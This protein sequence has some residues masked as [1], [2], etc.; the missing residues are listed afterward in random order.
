MSDTD[1]VYDQTTPDVAA[2]AAPQDDDWEAY[3]PPQQQAAPLPSME[4]YQARPPADD[5]EPYQ[6]KPEAHGALGTFT[7]ELAHDIGPAAAGA[8]AGA[9]TYGAAASVFP[10]IGTVG[11]LVAGGVGGFLGGMAAEKVQQTG[12]DLI[13]N[14][15]ADALQRAADAEAHPWAAAAASG[16]SNL[17]GFGRGAAGQA[18]AR[19]LGAGVGGGVATAQEAYQQGG[20][21]F[22]PAGIAKAAP[23]VLAQT[24]AGALFPRPRG[25]VQAAEAWG[26]RMAGARPAAAPP[27]A[28]PPP[29]GPAQGDFG[30]PEATVPNAQAGLPFYEAP[31]PY[32]PRAPGQGPVIGHP[33]LNLGTPAGEQGQLDLPV[34]EGRGGQGGL[35]VRANPEQD[36]MLNALGDVDTTPFQRRGMNTD[37]DLRNLVNSDNPNAVWHSVN[38]WEDRRPAILNYGEGQQDATLNRMQTLENSFLE[39]NENIRDR[40][41]YSQL[42]RQAGI[43]PATGQ[44]NW[45]RL[46]QPDGPLGA[47]DVR[48]LMELS[49]K[50]QALLAGDAAS[51]STFGAAQGRQAPHGSPGALAA[52]GTAE[53]QAPPPKPM[54]DEPGHG[55]EDYGK[56]QPTGE[57]GGGVNVQQPG[58]PDPTLGSVLKPPEQGNLFDQPPPM[59]EH[60]PEP[61][62]PA[63]P[64][65]PGPPAAAP[66]PAPAEHPPAPAGPPQA[67][68]AE[69]KQTVG[70]LSLVQT[71]DGK[72]TVQDA[73]GNILSAHD[74]KGQAY[75]SRNKFLNA[76]AQAPETET[77]P[78]AAPVK[79]EPEAPPAAAEV[80]KAPE[81]PKPAPKGPNILHKMEPE[82]VFIRDIEGDIKKGHYDA[83]IAPTKSLADFKRAAEARGWVEGAFGKGRAFFSPDG[84]HYMLA[85]APVEGNN[86]NVQWGRVPKDI[87]PPGKAPAAAPKAAPAAEPQAP[88]VTPTQIEGRQPGD[89]RT[90]R[91]DISAADYAQR[92]AELRADKPRP[93]NKLWNDPSK[94]DPVAVARQQQAIKDW[95]SE[96]NRVSKMQKLALARDNAAMQAK[97]AEAPTAPKEPK[98]FDGTSDAAKKFA[99]GKPE[100]VSFLAKIG[101]P[102]QTLKVMDKTTLAD[103]LD[104]YQP[105]PGLWGD[106]QNLVAQRLKARVGNMPVYLIP[107]KEMAKYN[108]LNDVGFYHRGEDFVVI[109]EAFLN[110]P[111]RMAHVVFHEA[112]HAITAHALAHDNKLID[113]THAIMRDV[114]QK[115][116]P[117]LLAQQEHGYGIYGGTYDKKTKVLNAREFIAEVHSNPEFQTTLKGI[118]LD[119]KT[120]AAVKQYTGGNTVTTAW[121]GVVDLVRS[122][123]YLAPDKMNALEAALHVTDRSM[124]LNPYH[125]A[126]EMPIATG[127][128][129]KKPQD[130]STDV[131]D[132]LKQYPKSPSP[133]EPEMQQA[134]K[135]D[136]Q[137]GIVPAIQRWLGVRASSTPSGRA[138]RNIIMGAQGE[139][140]QL[141]QISH[142]RF[143]DAM[144]RLLNQTGPAEQRM[145]VNHIQGGN[146]FP[147]YKPNPETQQVVGQLRQVY[148]DFENKM[149]SMPAFDQMNF[150][151][152]DKYLTGQFKNPDAAKNYFK[153]YAETTMAGGSGSTKKKFFPTDEDARRAGLE[154]ITTN[155][156]ERVLRYTDAMSNYIA[157]RQVIDGGKAQ[158]Y[159][160]YFSPETVGG[161]GTPDAYVRG[162][163]PEGWAPIRNLKDAGGRQG[164]APR[165]FAETMNNFY[166]AG[167]A[168]F[169]PKDLVDGVRRTSNAFTAMELGIA[170]YHAFTTVH[171]RISSAWS[172]ALS[173][174]AAGKFD[175]AARTM[176]HSVTTPITSIPEANRIRDVYLGNVKDAT[177]Q[178]QAIVQAMKDANFKPINAKHTLD[179]DMSKADDFVRS[180]S[181]GALGNEF[182][183]EYKNIIGDKDWKAGMTFAPRMMGR[184]MQTIAK[185]LF[186]YYIPRMK[187]AAFAENVKAW[188][189]ANPDYKPEDLREAAIKIGKSIDNRM[190]EMAHDNMMMNRSLRDGASIALR[191]FSFT[192]GGVFREI[193]GGAQS[194]ARGALKGENRLSMSSKNYDPRSAYALAFPA[195]VASMSMLYQ[196]LKTGKGPESWQDLIWPQTGGKQPGVGKGRTVP[197]RALLPGYHKD[198]AAYIAH[199]TREAGNKLAGLWS[200]IGDQIQGTKMTESGPQPIVPPGAGIG[201]AALARA[202]AFGEH[203]TPIFVRTAAKEPR[204]GTNISYPEQLVGLRAPG[205][206][207]ADMPGQHKADTARAEREWRAAERRVNTDRQSRGLPAL[208]PRVFTREKQQ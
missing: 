117:K 169:V 80:P 157:Y 197:E 131:V 127:V 87:T 136:L 44:R 75:I 199:P 13:G 61:P 153:T 138:A 140:E 94:A 174:M 74:L 130:Y 121:Q 162:K 160:K 36:R 45:D 102:R 1:N 186:E 35:Q 71:P 183:A 205:K 188:M 32:D 142:A 111:K 96:Y 59:P 187:T 10:G 84:Q 50:R 193:G 3:A 159:I 104:K 189:E 172:T 113:A 202:K 134:T 99:A 139:K 68:A 154:P 66:P 198:I 167:I 180:W 106:I 54:P 185:P 200:A 135:E 26:G 165:E 93:V 132:P 204:K 14:G 76:Q 25:Y 114:A 2:P 46:G 147:N 40:M 133:K 70:G 119:P 191:S 207:A 190:G 206:W 89:F 107:G 39:G 156:I 148:Q 91:A 37:M 103:A 38:T 163:P 72:W 101:G 145:L 128:P 115:I 175:S 177:P 208:P 105:R 126:Q 4:Q 195:A 58:Q 79:P 53:A 203:A 21:L 155:P 67:A 77:P 88:K 181:R 120:A 137:T 8:V 98:G 196:F 51:R 63:A 144:H 5:W 47:M 78:A 122:V 192:I 12:L 123:L 201:E 48:R 41:E 194:L 69:A 173:Q 141:Q 170:T 151:D 85:G 33:E 73:Q 176:A 112:V 118:T 179:Y 83:N 42:R 24:A 56:K 18:A 161:A 19:L 64:A 129:G 52:A 146:D 49:N 81:A 97:Q 28:Q 149:R 164:Y 182:A 9:V 124:E 29:A 34:P 23:N 65:A 168:G 62:P 22:T 158:G 171:E 20:D 57:G 108:R 17:V 125:K 178:E 143:T 110:D 152:N 15:Q 7:S 116:D 166:G 86:L 6:P 60:P 92:M 109:N 184:A 16:V 31:Q 27:P 95:N 11:G 43:D 30:F 150:W 55:P 82:E 100:T 90:L